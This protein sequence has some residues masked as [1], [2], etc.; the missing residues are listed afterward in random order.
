MFSPVSE[1]RWAPTQPV[2]GRPSTRRLPLPAAPAL[3]LVLSG[4]FVDPNASSSRWDDGSTDYPYGGSGGSGSGGYSGGSGS[5][6]NGS[7][8]N[9]SSGSGTSGSG[10]GG[11]GSGGTCT[12]A[13]TVGSC[14][15]ATLTYCDQ[16]TSY[17]LDCAAS[18]KICAYDPTNEWYDCLAP[19][20][21]IADSC[22]AVTDEGACNG[23]ELQYCDG[24]KLYAADCVAHGGTCGWVASKSWYDCVSV[25][26][27]KPPT[28]DTCGGVT[29]AG[30]CSGDVLSVCD[31]GGVVTTDCAASGTEC[32]LDESGAAFCGVPVP[33]G[34]CGD[35]TGVGACDGDTVVWCDGGAL[36]SLDCAAG[37]RI[38]GWNDGQAFYDCVDPPVSACGDVDA[39]GVCDGDLLSYC[40]DGGLVTQ[41]CDWGCGW[42]ADA[43]YYDCLAE[44]VTPVDPCE[45]LD[46]VGTC[47]GDVL[48][49]C[50]D[51]VVY[52]QICAFGCGWN[53]AGGFNECAS[54]PCNGVDAAGY[55]DGEYVTYCQSDVLVSELCAFGCGVAPDG[56]A[57][58]LP[59]PAACGDIDAVGLCDGDVL[60]YCQEGA[61]IS[62]VCDLACGY[63]DVGGVFRCL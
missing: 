14:S 28:R 57:E 62:E 60:W 6:S 18:G 11:S 12:A 48:S 33:A 20:E 26:S 7:G 43:A 30:Q 58:C 45:G 54:D 50:Q 53:V 21:Q 59:D 49:Y 17:Q 44:P 4:C 22:G 23:D 56:V 24:G 5:G 2:A 41:A 15:G 35:V 61:L 37:G 19:A 32:M 39:V 16:G 25:G 47:A 42:N 36:A 55:C 27:R 29:A 8:S 10:S 34:A 63:D 31:G 3:A 13:A 40:Q 1:S 51:S 38:C 9:G 46:A 52:D